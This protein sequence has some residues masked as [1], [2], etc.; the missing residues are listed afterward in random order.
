M[1]EGTK[2]ENFI[3]SSTSLVEA[4]SMFKNAT[5]FTTFNGEL[6]SLKYADSMFE[7]TILT[8]DWKTSMPN[9]ISANYMFTGCNIPSFNALLSSL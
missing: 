3:L 8:T 9:L 2:I 5:T 6:E 7:G 1:F 4:N